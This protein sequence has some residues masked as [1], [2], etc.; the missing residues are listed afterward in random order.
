MYV[1]IQMLFQF[2]KQKVYL[3]LLINKKFDIAIQ[4]N[5]NIV[6][7]RFSKSDIIKTVKS[8]IIVISIIFNHLIP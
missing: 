5:W 2:I 3:G 6:I 1:F 8:V 4:S 7:C